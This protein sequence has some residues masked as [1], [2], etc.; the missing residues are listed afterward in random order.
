MTTQQP[1]NPTKPTDVVVTKDP[2]AEADLASRSH[3]NPAVVSDNNSELVDPDPAFDSPD[4]PSTLRE[5]TVAP[6]EALTVH[7]AHAGMSGGGQ[8]VYTCSLCSA[9]VQENSQVSHTAWHQNGVS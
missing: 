5:D 9:L 8:S 3:G 4:S 6:K 2:Q 7:Y 1:V